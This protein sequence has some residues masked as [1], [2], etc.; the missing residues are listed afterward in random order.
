MTTLYDQ[1]DEHARLVGEVRDLV[2]RVESVGDRLCERLA[3]GGVL[4]TCGNGG[5]A[6]DAQHLAAELVGRYLRRRR[7]LAAVALT[8]D[9]SVLTCI[10]NDYTYSDVF[11]RQVEALATGRDMV[12]GFTTSGRSESV[13]RALAAARRA[14]AYTVAFTGAGGAALA[15][16]VD[17]CFVVPTTA[18][19]RVQEMHLMLLHL[20]SDHVDEWAAARV[21]RDADP[22]PAGSGGRNQ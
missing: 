19:A 3:A 20:L 12:V 9:P 4:Y 5:S 6:A 8:T 10:A 11:A 18:T 1:V 2:G 14:G 17:T 22:A 21:P 16:E 13:V 15:G 7:P